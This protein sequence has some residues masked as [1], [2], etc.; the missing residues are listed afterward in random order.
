MSLDVQQFK[1]DEITV[2]VVDK[3]I[4]IEGKHE[5]QQ[6]EHGF[7][8][9]QFTRKYFIPEQCDIDAVKSSLSSDGV[10]SITC[11]RKQIELT[12]NEK[13]VPIEHTG[14]PAIVSKEKAVKKAEE[15]PEVKKTEKM[16]K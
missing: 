1:P 3:F 7:I 6:D 2:K 10:L 12:G 11:P 13:V 9:R 5:E 16:I 8:S 14:K 15:K 4:V